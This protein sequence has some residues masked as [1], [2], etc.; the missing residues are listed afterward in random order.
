[1]TDALRAPR[2][3]RRLPCELTTVPPTAGSIDPAGANEASTLLTRGID[4]CA[5]VAICA[6]IVAGLG[7][8]A[9]FAGEVTGNGK[10][11]TVKGNSPC[12]FSGQEDLQ[13]FTDDVGEVPKPGGPTKGDP[14]HVQSWCQI[15]RFAGPLG[16]AA[17][18]PFEDGCNAHLYGLK[19]A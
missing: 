3:A 10:P 7:A 12:A 2:P 5:M 13:F 11:L 18:T 15:I 4:R 9:A 19:N 17:D 8:N 6:A 1:M 14:A 16:G